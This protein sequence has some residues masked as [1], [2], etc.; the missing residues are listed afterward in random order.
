MDPQTAHEKLRSRALSLLGIPTSV[1]GR[2]TAEAAPRASAEAAA[3]NE[4]LLYGPIVDDFKRSFVSYCMDDEE[5]VVSNKSFRAAM[6]DVRGDVVVRINSPGGDVWEASGMMTAI[7]ERRNGGDAVSVVVDG[8]AASAASLVMLAAAEIQVAPLAS[9]MIHQA[10]GLMYG[11]APKFLD[12]AAFLE[13]VDRQAAELYAARTGM[14][15][16]DVL[17]AIAEERWFTGEE[18]VEAGLADGVITLIESGAAV[19]GETDAELFG[20][21][22]LRLAALFGAAA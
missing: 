2:W 14:T 7:T 20:G 11:P 8:L 6:A 9:V 21:R 22:N 1:Q 16:D 18:A 15:V 19:D 10:R 13:R 12:M 4:V 17:V 3:D 5:L